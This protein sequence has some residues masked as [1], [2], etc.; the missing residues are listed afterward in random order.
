[1]GTS[2][3]SN[4]SPSG[5]PMVPA[6]VPE[7]PQRPTPSDGDLPSHD[8]GQEES[9]PPSQ[10]ASMAPPG[11]FQ[12]VNR[13]L[14]DYARTGKRSSMNR[15]LGQYVKK[16]YGGSSTATRRMG[17]TTQTAQ[18]LYSVLSG[19]TS[20]N[21]GAAEDI[22]KLT[23]G[24]SADE[25]MDAIIEVVR[26]V[27]GTQDAEANRASIKDALSEVLNRFPDADLIN[28]QPDQRE[29]AIEQFVAADVFRRIDLDVGKTVR[30]KA[31]NAVTGLKRL[32]EMREYVKEAVSASFRKLKSIGQVLTTGRVTNIVQSA[33]SETFE[34]FEGYAK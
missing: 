18:S 5:V 10:S 24:R 33:I 12:G 8:P 3:S 34:V 11:R 13:N 7:I 6:W 28:L 29:L 14:G 4:G 19:D 20:F 1:M 9:K 23:S 15:G 31:P 30:E 16:G 25:I 22:K 17:G 27:D 32:K 26:P 21:D 2:Q